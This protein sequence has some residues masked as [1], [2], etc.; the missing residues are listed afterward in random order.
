[1]LKKHMPNLEHLKLWSF[2]DGNAYTLWNVAA[3]HPYK[4]LSRQ[5]Q[6]LFSIMKL[7]AFL[8]HP[9]LIRVILPAYSGPTH[10]PDETRVWNH[11]ILDTGDKR[12]ISAPRM[13]WTDAERS[14]K[15][16]IKVGYLSSITEERIA[17]VSQDVVLNAN[18]LRQTRKSDMANLPIDYFVVDPP[19]GQSPA[20]IASSDFPDA[21]GIYGVLEERAYK[22]KAYRKAQGWAWRGNDELLALCEDLNTKSM[23]TREELT[24]AFS[25]D[26]EKLLAENKTLK[27]DR[28]DAVKRSESLQSQVDYDLERRT[29]LCN[30]LQKE[31]DAR[32]ALEE[33]LIH[34]KCSEQNLQGELEY[35]EE[36]LRLAR[37][38]VEK[39]KQRL[40]SARAIG[41]DADYVLGESL[42]LRE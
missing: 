32:E 16:E 12:L 37:A 18:L 41:G 20:A 26:V 1:M 34:A 35:V 21:I 14:N 3:D 8:R 27:Y 39:L 36:D 40:E 2:H 7:A 23:L 6:E 25:A 29:N 4:D 5:Q 11:I 9:K 38:R 13:K 33:E 22:T 17:N 30:Q 19:I 31:K 42:E 15:V 10:E 24:S 28:D